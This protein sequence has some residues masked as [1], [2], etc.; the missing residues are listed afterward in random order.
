MNEMIVMSDV[1]V[2]FAW[3]CSTPL[4][5]PV[6]CHGIEYPII[7]C[8]SEHVRY[9]SAKCKMY[10]DTQIGLP[11]IFPPFSFYY[12]WVFWLVEKMEFT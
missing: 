4:W 7:F 9:L 5:N 11:C 3:L 1:N 10:V 6:C 12:C 8:G 2:C